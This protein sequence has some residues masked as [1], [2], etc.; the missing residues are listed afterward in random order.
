MT[1][2]DGKRGFIGCEK[3]RMR[4]ENAPLPDMDFTP[5]QNS[6]RFISIG[7]DIDEDLLIKLLQ[8]RG[9]L[10]ANVP[11]PDCSDTCAAI[12]SRR[13]GGKMKYCS[14]SSCQWY[15]P[16]NLIAKYFQNMFIPKMG[17]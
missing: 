13:S 8:S 7:L 1:N 12:V 16:F 11:P 10:P 5:P 14:M 6:H 15:S 9:K 3:Y 4:S 2:D 17:A